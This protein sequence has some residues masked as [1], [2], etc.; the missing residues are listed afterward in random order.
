MAPRSSPTGQER[1]GH[2]WFGRLLWT[3]VVPR[4]APR[5]WV[6]TGKCTAVPKREEG[7]TSEEDPY[8]WYRKG[9]ISPDFKI[10]EVLL[11]LFDKF[12]EYINEKAS[13][14]KKESPSSSTCLLPAYTH[15]T[16]AS[17]Q[18][19]QRHQSLR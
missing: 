7:V 9:P 19:R 8:G 14:A 15:R 12:R 2:Q 18:G 4:H 16:S 17:I 11:H 6:D 3:P 5:V 13:A 10:D 1:T